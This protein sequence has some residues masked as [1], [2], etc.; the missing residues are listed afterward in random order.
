MN[1]Q[2]EKVG[3]DYFETAPVRWE[4]TEVIRAT[5][6]EIFAVFLDGPSWTKWVFA[7]TDVKWTSP[8]PIDVGSTRSVHM[9]GGLVGHEEF[10]AWEPGKRMAFRFNEVSKGGIDAFAEDYTVTDIGDGRCV[11]DWVMAMTPGGSTRGM[12]VTDPV[13]A[14]FIRHTLK[15]FR[16]YVES[17][18]VMTAT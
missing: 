11:V 8:F 15:N 4:A 3:L 10:I 14:A 16:K 1:E 17:S 18:P 7:I 13:M 5:P 9:R 6:E 12:S 2:C